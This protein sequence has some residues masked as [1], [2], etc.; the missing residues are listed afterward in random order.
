[1]SICLDFARILGVWYY[2]EE[3]LNWPQSADASSF[4][5]SR[6]DF[7]PECGQLLPQQGTTEKLEKE[8]Y[9]E[10]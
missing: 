6:L 7:C 8:E 4:D 2:K 10:G 5:I 1:M 9:D 3:N